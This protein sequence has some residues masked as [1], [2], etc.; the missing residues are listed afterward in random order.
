MKIFLNMPSMH[1]SMHASIALADVQIRRWHLNVKVKKK[2]YRK[3]SKILPTVCTILPI[4][5]DRGIDA[6]NR[7]FI[8]YRFTTSTLTF[9]LFF[10]SQTHNRWPCVRE[11]WCKNAP[12]TGKWVKNPPT[13]NVFPPNH[14]EFWFQSIILDFRLTLKAFKCKKRTFLNLKKI[15]Q[16]KCPDFWIWKNQTKK[17][18][19]IFD[20][21]FLVFSNS[22][23]PLFC[24]G[25]HL[26]TS[27]N[28]RSID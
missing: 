11:V 22:K 19:L 17:S 23:D 13:S 1:A 18:V 12:P 6:M 21:V 16:K 20:L 7:L 4:Y 24:V 2:T 3:K 5:D 26:E 27:S 10:I 28:Q 25:K 14:I 8:F 15:K 9:F